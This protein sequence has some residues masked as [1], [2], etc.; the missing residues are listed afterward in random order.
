MV[1]SSYWTVL[2]QSWLRRSDTY[3]CSFWCWI[4][5]IL[6]LAP[7]VPSNF[8]PFLRPSCPSTSAELLSDPLLFHSSILVEPWARFPLHCTRF[9]SL[10][11]VKLA[12]HCRSGKLAA[13]KILDLHPTLSS[14]ASALANAGDKTEKMILTAEREI[15][16]MKVC[17]TLMWRLAVS[18][19]SI[20]SPSRRPT[21]PQ[22]P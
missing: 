19:D 1:F 7:R 5:S 16:V 12:R 10:G 11:R 3:S 15:A 8:V 22:P 2:G 20:S 13:V 18:N 4:W 17:W 21:A 9:S 6:S 14:R